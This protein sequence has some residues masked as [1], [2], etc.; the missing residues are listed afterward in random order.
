VS[1]PEATV[2]E[3]SNG[4]LMRWGPVECHICKREWYGETRIH[5]PRGIYAQSE[6][7]TTAQVWA[8]QDAELCCSMLFDEEEE[9]D[10]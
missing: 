4:R 8:M 6:A 5:D 2:I 10:D 7:L 3:I 9:G 1:T